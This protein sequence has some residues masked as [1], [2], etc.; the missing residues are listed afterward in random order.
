MQKIV[1]V[2]A[3]LS[4]LVSLGVVVGGTKIYLE[5]DNMI[6]NIKSQLIQGV[7]ESITNALPGIVDSSIPEPPTT[8]GPV[9]PF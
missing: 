1:N 6:N 2:I 7:T 9:L 3:L 8:T 4:G 5:K